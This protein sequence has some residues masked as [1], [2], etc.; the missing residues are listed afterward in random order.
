MT[1]DGKLPYD[2]KDNQGIKDNMVFDPW[3]KVIDARRA[4][5]EMSEPKK[6]VAIVGFASSSRMMAPF[7]DP[8]WEIWGVNQLSRYIPRATRWFEIHNRPMFEADIVR[9]TNYIGWLRQCRIPVYMDPLGFDAGLFAD[10]PNAVR[11]PIEEAT[12]RFGHR[13]IGDQEERP[14]FTSTPAYMMALALMLGFEEIGVWGIDLVVGREY[15]YE[16]CCAEYFLGIAK[17]MGVKLAL[18]NTTAMLKSKFRYGIDPTPEPGPFTPEMFES[19]RKQLGERKQL[20]VNEIGKMQTEVNAIDGAFQENDF[21]RSNADLAAKNA[22]VLP[23][24]H[25]P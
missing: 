16:K 11:F 19:R 8:S 12:K 4:I 18:P 10:I 17:G 14:Y 9:D 7:G 6:R 13:F 1:T 21:W 25:G 23:S 2:P 20:L 22:T 5:V 24:T 15:D 3:A